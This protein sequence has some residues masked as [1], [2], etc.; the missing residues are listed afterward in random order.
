MKMKLDTKGRSILL[1]DLLAEEGV[2]LQ[3]PCGG[4][5]TCGKCAVRVLSGDARVLSPEQ[6]KRLRSEGLLAE[7]E[8]LACQL[9]VCGSLEI[10][11]GYDDEAGFYIPENSA[12]QDHEHAGQVTADDFAVLIDIGTTTVC[13]ALTDLNGETVYAKTALLNRQR[14]FGA[15]VISRIRAAQEGHA[16]EMQ[17]LICEDLKGGIGQLTKAAGLQNAAQVRKILIAGN[18]TM[19]HLL[20]GRDVSS[21]GQYPFTPV[22]LEME[23]MIFSE[24]SGDRELCGSARVTILPGLSAFVGADIT[25]GL[26]SLQKAKKPVFFIDLGTNAEMALM[27]ED[28]LFVSSAAAG[29][30]FEGGSISCGTGS[31]QGAVS[32]AWRQYGLWR[33]ETIEKRPPAGICGSGLISVIAAMIRAGMIDRHGT[34]QDMY[35]GRVELVPGTVTMTQA[36][37]RAFQEAKAA[38]RSG[39]QQL[40]EAACL[41]AEDIRCI[42]L[43]G[44]FGGGMDPEDACMAGILPEAFAGKIKA[45]GNTVLAGLQQYLQDGSPEKLRQMAENAAVINLPMQDDFRAMYIQYLDF[46]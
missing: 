41:A 38:V 4:Q 34:L 6:E 39:I 11:T 8:H 31:I 12:A 19:L 30:A 20:R 40:L 27:T 29:P 44:S 14:R 24:L 26:L 35:H 18:T 28:R 17:Q 2:R 21:L 23:E 7:D 16:A 45:A 33:Y 1:T 32:R 22:S 15:D 10:E 37:I 46:G 42:C 3:T 9:K 36:D 25:A 5:G 43:A 13:F